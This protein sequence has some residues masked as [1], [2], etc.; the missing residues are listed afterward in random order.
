MAPD[1]AE[2]ERLLSALYQIDR[3]KPVAQRGPAGPARRAWLLYLKVAAHWLDE[4][5]PAR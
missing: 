4:A 3:N 1:R 2:H 5:F